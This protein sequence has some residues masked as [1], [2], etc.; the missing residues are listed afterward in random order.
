MSDEAIE[1][2]WVW[3]RNAALALYGIRSVQPMTYIT[4]EPMELMPGYIQT[5]QGEPPV[6]IGYTPQA[7][8]RDALQIWKAVEEARGNE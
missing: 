8:V 3:V 1:Q 6:V 2:K 5:Y 7:A 4:K